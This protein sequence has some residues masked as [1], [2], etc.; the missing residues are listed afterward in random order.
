MNNSKIMRRTWL[1]GDKR[2]Q[3]KL[4]IAAII[5]NHGR[6]SYSELKEIMDG[7]QFRL[8]FVKRNEAIRLGELRSVIAELYEEGLVQGNSDMII[9][10]PILE[11][12]IINGGTFESMNTTVQEV[13]A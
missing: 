8:D 7:V 4:R 10:T 6:I 9:S 2:R 13:E 1:Q 5:Y 12:W 11:Q 3:F